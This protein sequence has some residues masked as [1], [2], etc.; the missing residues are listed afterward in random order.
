MKIKDYSGN[1]IVE[2]IDEVDTKIETGSTKTN[3]D[4]SKAAS[5]EY[6]IVK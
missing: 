6:S 1:L 3:V 4:L 2:L 5:I